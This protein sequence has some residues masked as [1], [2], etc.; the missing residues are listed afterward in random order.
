MVVTMA[1]PP[2]DS[3]RSSCSRCMAVVLSRPCNT[4]IKQLFKVAVGNL[5]SCQYCVDIM[6]YVWL[7]KQ[8][9]MSGHHQRW[10]YSIHPDVSQS[11]GANQ[12]TV[13]THAVIECCLLKALSS[14]ASKEMSKHS[15]QGRHMATL[16]WLSA[17]PAKPMQLCKKAQ[18]VYR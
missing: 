2:C 9:H 12:W 13:M 14:S 11:G 16:Q 17:E 1:L 15:T 3:C 10:M 4:T 8:A 7:L 5:L 18:N 6:N